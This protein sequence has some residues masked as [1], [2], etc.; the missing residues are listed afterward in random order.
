MTCASMASTVVGSAGAASSCPGLDVSTTP[1]S[2]ASSSSSGVVDSTPS[3][4]GATALSKART[5]ARSFLRRSHTKSATKSVTWRSQSHATQAAANMQKF[6]IAGIRVHEPARNAAASVIEVVVMEGPAI[7]NA[8]Q[9]RRAAT[10]STVAAPDR[11]AAAS[12]SQCAVPSTL[13][14]VA[15]PMMTNA[16]SMPTPRTKNAATV[17]SGVAQM[18][19]A[20]QMPNPAATASP[21]TATACSPSEPRDFLGFLRSLSTAYA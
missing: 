19:A 6:E 16:S 18:P 2:R 14:S 15:A 21:T 3:S 4:A 9:A 11:M 13:A 7:A 17:T 8:T 5:C 10:S 1:P 20:K 12:A